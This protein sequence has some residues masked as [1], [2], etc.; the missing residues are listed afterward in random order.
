MPEIRRILVPV[1][2]SEPSENALD[3]AIELAAKFGADVQAIHAYQL[4]VYALPDGAM[5]AGPEFTTKVTAELQKALEELASR[6]SG[7][8]LETHLLEGIPYKEVVRM[9]EE[10][11]AD[12]VVMGTHGRT[13]LKHLLL[14]SVAERVVR[15]SKVPVITVPSGEG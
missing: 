10:L 5:M 15:S 13:G 4:P 11:D 6:K 7:V 9:T 12:L 1:D 14:G 2:F 3:Y 8:K